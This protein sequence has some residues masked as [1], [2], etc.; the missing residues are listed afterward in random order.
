M[1]VSESETLVGIEVPSALLEPSL[2][3]HHAEVRSQYTALIDLDRKYI[4]VS[5][6]F[7][8]LLGRTRKQLIGHRV[9]DVTAP[10]TVDIQ[11]VYDGFMCA[12]YSH[13][14][15]LLVHRTGTRIL[16]RYDAA[17]REDKIAV[18]ME[19]VGAAY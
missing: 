15:W 9:D 4:E 11:A 18:R 7:C 1:C 2:R 10:N 14:L 6:S 19:L 5:D 8:R 3:M 12:G 16:V 13:G 17:L